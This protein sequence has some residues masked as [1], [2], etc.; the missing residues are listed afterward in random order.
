MTPNV[1]ISKSFLLLTPSIGSQWEGSKFAQNRKI[2]KIICSY[3]SVGS[4]RNGFKRASFLKIYQSFLQYPLTYTKEFRA[5]LSN[6]NAYSLQFVY[7]LPSTISADLDQVCTTDHGNN[8]RIVHGY[9]NRWIRHLK[10]HIF[11]FIST[12]PKEFLRGPLHT[13][14][15][16]LLHI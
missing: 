4:H 15:Q 9:F 8:L 7:E 3:P 5:S 2:L 16:S 13:K 10:A 11:Y 1:T 12:Y 6:Q 14:L